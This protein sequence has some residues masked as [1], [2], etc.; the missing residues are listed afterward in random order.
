MDNKKEKNSAMYEPLNPL[1][2]IGQLL[3]YKIDET[4]LII[5]LLFNGPLPPPPTSVDVIN[6][7]PLMK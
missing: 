6:E 2:R 1:V 3:Y 4:S 7:A 5:R